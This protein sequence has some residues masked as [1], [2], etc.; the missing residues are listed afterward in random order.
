MVQRTQFHGVVQRVDVGADRLVNLEGLAV[1]RVDLGEASG[2]VVHLLTA[3]RAAPACPACGVLSTSLKGR[4]TTRPRDVGYGPDQLELVWHKSRW[5]CRE[6]ECPRASFT[7]SVPQ[8]PARSRI[9]QRA[10]AQCG[11]GIGQDFKDVQAG[12]AYFGMSWP[13]AHAAFIAHTAA[14][15]DAPLPP[16]SVLGIDEIR[17]GKPQW[18][19]D[20]DSGKWAITVDRH[21]RCSWHRRA[22]GARRGPHVCGG[23]GLDQ[24]P[25]PGMA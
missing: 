19:Q 8:V 1:A 22:P 17:R 11:A 23:Y 15:L 20:P 3:S 2:R 5:R 7:E 12:G 6:R 4:A 10:R 24:G 13:I 25:T 18:A 9:T 21:R 14:E 16:V